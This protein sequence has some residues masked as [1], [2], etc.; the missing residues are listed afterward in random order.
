MRTN[1]VRVQ[2]TSAGTQEVAR[3]P[4]TAPGAEGPGKRETKPPTLLPGDRRASA[5][6]ATSA[7]HR[8]CRVRRTG[9][10]AA[11]LGGGPLLFTLW[12]GKGCARS[13]GD[14]VGKREGCV[15]EEG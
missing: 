10:N 8:V 5:R 4:G 14:R 2:G 15:K 12:R 9:F 11:R 1:R 13:D 6:A 3:K 7:T